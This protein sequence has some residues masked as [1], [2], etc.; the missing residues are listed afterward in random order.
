[1]GA[2]TGG[3]AVGTVVAASKVGG[4]G[5]VSDVMMLS[6]L[7]VN[8]DFGVQALG[9]LVEVTIRQRQNNGPF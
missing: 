9:D 6:L 7:V 2:G 8:R 3:E 1:V 5:D 4:A